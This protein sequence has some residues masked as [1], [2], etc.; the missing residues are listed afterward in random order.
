MALCKYG[1]VLSVHDIVVVH[2]GRE[3]LKQTR[4]VRCEKG[5]RQNRRLFIKRQA[6]AA[7][8]RIAIIVAALRWIFKDCGTLLSNSIVAAVLPPFQTR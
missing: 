8:A 7:H 5:S 2:S 4:V 6:P 3:R 1:C